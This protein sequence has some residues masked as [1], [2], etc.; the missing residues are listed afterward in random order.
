VALT[1]IATEAT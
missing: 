1:Y